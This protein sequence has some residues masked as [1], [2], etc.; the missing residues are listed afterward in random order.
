MGRKSRRFRRSWD[1][2][3]SV[4]PVPGQERGWDSRSTQLVGAFNQSFTGALVRGSTMIL[5]TMRQDWRSE[6]R[7]TERPGCK[8]SAQP[9]VAD[10]SMAMLMNLIGGG[11]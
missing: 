10:K 3:G 5:N 6:R 9:N 1:I 4:P 7:V 11:A 2:P 8:F